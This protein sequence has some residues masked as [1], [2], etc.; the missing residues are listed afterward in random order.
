MEKKTGRGRDGWESVP[1]EE[2]DYARA[3]PGE[4]IWRR[5]NGSEES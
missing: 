2:A 4:G 1:K 5:V 3:I